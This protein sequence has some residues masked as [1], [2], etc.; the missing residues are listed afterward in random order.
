MEPAELQPGAAR[1]AREETPLTI[2]DS[3]RYQ[4]ASG[5]MNPMHHDADAARARGYANAFTVGMLPAGALAV[6]VA[7]WI[8]GGYARRFAVRFRNQSWP[9]DTLSYSARVK[10]LREAA[11]GWE[12][13]LALAVA[14]QDGTVCLDG[15][16]TW[17]VPDGG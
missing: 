11:S 4:G 12:V 15:E 7:A 13:D 10:E 2:T 14:N 5:D 3:V 8:G 9:G 17:V 16:A 1:P 6:R